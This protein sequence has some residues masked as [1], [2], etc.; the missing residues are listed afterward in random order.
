MMLLKETEGTIAPLMQKTPDS[1]GKVIVIYD[2]GE[3]ASPRSDKRFSAHSTAVIL[4]SEE[5][6]KT[7]LI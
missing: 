7:I 5:N 6:P 3:F 4:L 2:D 1:V